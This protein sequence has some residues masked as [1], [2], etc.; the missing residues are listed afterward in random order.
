MEA[1][2][3][4]R[5]EKSGAVMTFATLVVL[6]T[7]GCSN[8]SSMP[9]ESHMAGLPIS[10]V[11]QANNAQALTDLR[12]MTAAF[13]NVAAAEAAHYGLLVAPP[14]TAPDGCISDMSAGGMGYHY[15]QGDNLADN[16]IDLLDPEFLVYAP[17]AASARDGVQGRRLGAVEYFIPY[18]DVWP[19]PDQLSFDRAPRLSDFPSFAGLPDVAMAPTRFGG[20]AIHIWLWENNPGGMLSNYNTAVSKC[21]GSTF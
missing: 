10:A 14:L 12:K 13:H 5:T 15:T 3:L 6:G 20:W 4:R 18:S 11:S 9:T 19:G 16:S 17:T 2:V 21:E 7:A 1:T 8:D